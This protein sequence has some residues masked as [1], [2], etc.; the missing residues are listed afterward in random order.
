MVCGLEWGMAQALTNH[1][2]ANLDRGFQRVRAVDVDPF[3]RP[4]AISTVV[5][6]AEDGLVYERLTEDLWY[7]PGLY[8]AIK[9]DTLVRDEQDF[10]VLYTPENI[11]NVTA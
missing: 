6:G 3:L 5:K 7:S 2:A 4:A 8:G 11:P 9:T 10:F 1:P